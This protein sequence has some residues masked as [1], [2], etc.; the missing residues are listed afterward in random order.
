M[1]VYGTYIDLRKLG[2]EDSAGSGQDEF[3]RVAK[4]LVNIC[5]RQ[6]ILTTCALDD[7]CESETPQRIVCMIT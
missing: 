3:V 5:I 1:H 6:S 2:C 4:T 7:S